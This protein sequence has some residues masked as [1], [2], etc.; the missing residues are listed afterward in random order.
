MVP[1]HL[2]SFSCYSCVQPG[3][4]HPV[5][6]QM[7][8]WRPRTFVGISGFRDGVRC[9]KTLY[10]IF[11][12]AHYPDLIT[13][14]VV[15]Q[16]FACLCLLMSNCL[17]VFL[18]EIRSLSGFI[19][20]TVC[21]SAGLL[22]PAYLSVLTAFYYLARIFEDVNPHIIVPQKTRIASMY[23]V[24]Y[25]YKNMGTYLAHITSKLGWMYTTTWTPK[26]LLLLVI[27]K[28]Y[29]WRYRGGYLVEMMIRK[30]RCISC[31]SFFLGGGFLPPNRLSYHVG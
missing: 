6:P 15:D 5:P 7:P 2:Y 29:S 17:P 27:T 25:T 18:L 14:G 16:R 12:K 1:F 30:K 28:I 9:G 31:L 3:A 20:F 19:T 10:E 23:I 13:V 4:P 11:S 21:L 26:D 8:A 22:S 24:K